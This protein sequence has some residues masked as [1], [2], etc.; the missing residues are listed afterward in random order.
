MRFVVTTLDD[1]S[2]VWLTDIS[3]AEEFAELAFGKESE[4]K[5]LAVCELDFG[6][7]Q[8]GLSKVCQILMELDQVLEIGAGFT[9][10]L[11]HV[12]RLGVKTGMGIM[13]GE[14]SKEF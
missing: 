4:E 5:V 3:N 6:E 2:A 7:A 13:T 12:F 9:D 8:D 1:H 14:A 11:Q 10:I